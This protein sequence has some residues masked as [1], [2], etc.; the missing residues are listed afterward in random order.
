MAKGNR[1][2]SKRNTEALREIVTK[3]KQELDAYKQFAVNRANNRKY[4]VHNIGQ[5]LEGIDR[6][7]A[8]C[9]AN[10]KPLTVAGFI[11]HAFNVP[12]KSYYELKAG[13]KDHYIEEYIQTNNIDVDALPIIDGI[14]TYTDDNGEIIPLIPFSHLIEKCELLI[15]EQRET[16]CSSLK[17]N[18]AG[19]IFLLKAQQGFEDQPQEPKELHQNLIIA[20]GERAKD[21]IKLLNG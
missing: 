3:H 21:I 8:D 18:P 6:Y 2:N 11:L 10:N 5:Y 20:D 19:N 1:S 15:Q 14:P 7:V 17:G 13:D 9:R 16:A 12:S 4:S